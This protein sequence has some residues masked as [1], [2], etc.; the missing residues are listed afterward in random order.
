MEIWPL[1]LLLDL[2]LRDICVRSGPCEPLIASIVLNAP[3]IC[4]ETM[5]HVL[6]MSQLRICADG[7]SNVLY[8]S[9]VESGMFPAELAPHI[10]IGDL[11]SIR[12]DVR[13]FFADKGVEIEQVIDDDTTDLE[14]AVLYLTTQPAVPPFLLIL[15][16]I[17]A[18]EGRVDQFFSV[19]NVMYK[20][21]HTGSFRPIQLGSE[22]LMLVLDKGE[23]TVQLPA[24]V[25]GHHCGLI[26]IFGT[27]AKVTSTGLE[28]NL[29]EELGPMSFGG[30][31][32]TNNIIRDSSVYIQTSDPIL[33][34][35]TLI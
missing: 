10:I 28:W 21:R 32:S 7:G 25:V 15:G 17:G 31:V 29:S 16:S 8:D 12:P 9:C 6:R 5:A 2:A 35:I 1:G 34:T 13:S 3:V 20:Y 11:D 30:L 27:V 19:I 22:S 4:R 33:F 23:H 14:K 24:Y 26:P 18:H